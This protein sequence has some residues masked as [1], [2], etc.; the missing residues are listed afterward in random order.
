MPSPRSSSVSV[1]AQLRG[2]ATLRGLHPRAVDLDRVEL[3]RSAPISALLD[4]ARLEATIEAAGIN[5]EGIDE[6]PG[7]LREHFGGLRI[8]QYPVQF[9]PYL[10]TLAEF[11]IGSY[12]EV[13]VRHGGSFI[14]TVEYLRR[15]GTLTRAVAVDIIPATGLERYASTVAGVETA[16][17]DSTSAAFDRLL[18]ERGPFDLVF[19]DS[20]HEA[21]QCRSE[22]ARLARHARCIALHDITNVGCPGIGVVWSEM[23]ATD[24]WDCVEFREQPVGVTGGPYM[25]IGLA[26]T[27][28]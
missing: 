11:D 16:W 6:F 21:D 14:A 10:R 5:E 2:W 4:V 26:R 13:G 1:E 28:S 18:D 12:L 25:G 7:T 24:S 15:V 8:W 22:V 9:A 27:R 19:V 17:I 23:V 20:H 3:F